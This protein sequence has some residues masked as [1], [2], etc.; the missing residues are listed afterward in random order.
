MPSYFIGSGIAEGDSQD[1]ALTRYAQPFGAPAGDAT[2]ANQQILARDS[3]TLSDLF[4]RLT[5]N[6][7]N[8]TTTVKSRVGGAD[9]NQVVSIDAAATGAFTDDV[10][11]D[12]LVSGN[13][14]CTEIVTAGSS[15]SITYTIISY[16]LS[17]ASNTTPILATTGKF[18]AKSFPTQHPI[19]GGEA[20]ASTSHAETY[21]RYLFRVSAALTNLRIYVSENTADGTA[22]VKTRVD[23][24]DGNQAL[25]I[26]AGA[27]GAFEDTTHTDDISIGENV[28]YK[29][30]IVSSASIEGV[31][32][33]S[34]QLKSNSAG[35][36]C[37]VATPA[38]TFINEGLTVYQT[39]IGSGE[40]TPPATETNVKATA[41]AIFTA[42][43]MYVSV[44]LN[45]LDGTT[46]FRIRKNGADGNLVASVGADATGQFEDLVNSDGFIATDELNWK[47]VTGS[48]GVIIQVDI[49]G[50]ELEQVVPP[51][52]LG[53]IAGV[54]D[55]ASIM[56]V[57]VEDIESVKGVVSA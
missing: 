46:T 39:I 48:G 23:L 15:G 13:L 17:T 56:G 30:V 4:I 3:Y 38:G 25:S 40:I 32:M 41:R 52:W 31:N 29:L 12:S 36:Q 51:G 22:S 21:C 54:T 2:E 44:G 57:D 37:C 34:F 55:P 27:T 1:S 42:K 5:A 10:N 53:T 28:N 50:F 43:N 47:I 14:F 45:M 19:I 6:D 9:G 7:L 49:I 35:Q 18:F 24:G 11:S 26:G 33:R 8:G 16:I 20:Y